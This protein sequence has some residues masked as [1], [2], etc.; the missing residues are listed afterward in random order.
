MK[1]F[2]FRLILLLFL[3]SCA[4]KVEEDVES[5]VYVNLNNLI[6]TA[7]E[8]FERIDFIE[9]KS[10]QLI[11]SIYRIHE[12]DDGF[13]FL[14]KEKNKIYYSS[15]DGRLKRVFSGQGQGPSEY[16]IINNFEVSQESGDVFLFDQKNMNLLRLDSTLNFKKE[17]FFPPKTFGLFGG[18]KPLA[19][20]HLIFK[21][22]NSDKRFLKF[23]LLKQSTIFIDESDPAI[24]NLNFGNDK[25]FTSSGDKLTTI[26]P[27]TPE[28]SIFDH[29]LKLLN[30]IQ[31]KFNIGTI[32]KT[33]LYELQNSPEKL[34]QFIQNEEKEKVHSFGILETKNYYVIT[35]YLGTFNSGKN[36]KTI[37][38][39]E[40][41]KASTY[42]KLI[43]N[44]IEIEGGLVGV[45]FDDSLIFSVNVEAL[46]GLSKEDLDALKSSFK[47]TSINDNPF[48]LVCKIKSSSFL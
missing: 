5:E 27:L 33:E 11:S 45:Q 22:N 17:Y 9:I 18:F 13:Y 46:N 41:L 12:G 20:D 31:L 16:S 10:D 14:T 47:F 3:V 32:E 29:E 26:N 6:H 15:W 39:K 34:L 43:V 36:L 28:I 1:S 8:L 19:D 38:N 2:N 24:H 42:D 44:G 37:I 7:S 30:Q 48:L 40:T 23:D 4:S 25:V 35:Y 21:L